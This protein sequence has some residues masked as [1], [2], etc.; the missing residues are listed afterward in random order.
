M[1]LLKFL[2]LL[3]SRK[4][5]L[6]EIHPFFRHH[7]DDK[8]F[9]FYFLGKF[10]VDLLSTRLFPYE[11]T[12]S[13]SKFNI[14]VNVVHF[15][16]YPLRFSLFF[17]LVCGPLYQ[18]DCSKVFSHSID[19]IFSFVIAA[20]KLKKPIQKSPWKAPCRNHSAD[21]TTLCAGARI[22]LHRGDHSNSFTSTTRTITKWVNKG[23]YEP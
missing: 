16:L 21:I 20:T 23:I 11:F 1:I 12:T 17:A 18:L 22:Y 10:I 19:K 14:T 15:N 7:D 8:N 2:K 9:F 4:G 13:N 5:W 3:A 6:G